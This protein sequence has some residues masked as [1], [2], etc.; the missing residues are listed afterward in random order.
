MHTGFT[1]AA[2]VRVLAGNENAAPVSDS[3]VH[4]EDPS[5]TAREHA[6]FCA[7]TPGS[8]SAKR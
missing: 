1:A 3:A 7:T 5:G 8:A 4:K 2:I 6:R